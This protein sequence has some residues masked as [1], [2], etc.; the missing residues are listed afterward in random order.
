MNTPQSHTQ[1]SP[2]PQA[3]HSINPAMLAAYPNQ[4]QGHA[5]GQPQLSVQQMQQLYARQQHQQQQHQQHQ[6]QH[7]HQQHQQHQHQQQQ[8]QQQQ[9]SQGGSVNPAAL[10]NMRAPRQMAGAGVGMGMGGMV[11]PQQLLQQHQAGMNNMGEMHS[12]GMNQMQGMGGMS[13]MGGMNG[14]GGMG[15]MGGMG[16]GMGGIN[17][18]ALSAGM[19][20]PPSPRQ[21]ST[22]APGT[23]SA[24]TSPTIPQQSPT[25]SATNPLSPTHAQ[26]QMNQGQGQHPGQHGQ[27]QQHQHQS[28]QHVRSPSG[29]P[30]TPNPA[31]QMGGMPGQHAMQN[32]MQMNAQM[33]AQQH[34]LN[35]GGPGTMPL[36][37][38][39]FTPA[40]MQQLMQ[41]SLPE[42]ERIVAQAR[43]KQMAMSGMGHAQGM[44]GMGNM[45]GLQNMGGMG[46]GGQGMGGQGMG[47]QGMGGQ[48]M[49]NMNMGGMQGMNMGMGNM[50]VPNISNMQNMQSAQNMSGHGGMQNTGMNMQNMGQLTNAQMAALSM[51]RSASSASRHPSG[52]MAQG[53]GPNVGMQHGFQTPMQNAGQMPIPH[54]P[55]PN[56]PPG[57]ISQHGHSPAVL[58][59]PPSSIPPRPPTAASGRVSSQSHVHPHHPGHPG[60]QGQV[61]GYQPSPSPRPGTASRPGTSVSGQQLGPSPQ[62]SAT[63]LPSQGP[64]TPMHAPGPVPIQPRPPNLA[65]PP[66]ASPAPGT[67]PGTSM[68]FH[69]GG[70]SVQEMQQM[71]QTP[72]RPTTATGFH[73]P[74]NGPPQ[75]QGQGQGQG[76]QQNAPQRSPTSFA[77]IA[78]APMQSQTPGSPMRGAKRKLTTPAPGQQQLP[79]PTPQPQ[80]QIQQGSIQQNQG[81]NVGAGAMGARIGSRGSIPPQL[82]MQ[83]VDPT[84]MGMGLGPAQAGMNGAPTGMSRMV[85]GGLP[86]NL[87]PQQPL[88]LIPGVQSQGPLPET[89]TGRAMAAGMIMGGMQLPQNAMAVDIPRT[90]SQA[91]LPSLPPVIAPNAPSQ[92]VDRKV[93]VPPMSRGQSESAPAIPSANGVLPTATSVA[94]TASAGSASASAP[95]PASAPPPTIIPQLPPLPAGVNLNPKVT[96]VSVVPLVDS[97]TRIP[98]L[99]PHEIADIQTWMKADR[100]YE[101]LYRTMRDRMAEELRD[102]LGRPRAWYEQDTSGEAV[103]PRRRG[104]K[105]HL[106][107]YKYE[108]E[109]ERKKPGKRVGLRLP[110]RLPPEEADRPEQ[111]VPIRLEFDVEHHKMRDTFVWNLNDPVVTP[112]IFAQS[113]VEDYSLPSTYHAV[114]TKSIQDQL[115]DFKAHSTTFGEDGVAGTPDPEPVL[116]G[117]MEEEDAAW[118]EAWRKRVRSDTG[119]KTTSTPDTRSRKRRKVVKE[120]IVEQPDPL[121]SD[122]MD[123]DKTMAVHEFEDDESLAHE[124]MRILVKL[125]IIVG[126][127]KLED[128]FEWDMDNADPTP[129]QFAELYCREL[130][131]GG[132]FRTAI[133]HAIREQ[134]QIYQ[135]SLFLVGHPSD[136]TAVQDDDLRMSFLPSLTSAARSME[137]VGAFT[138]L[139]NYLSE[140]EIERNE[141][142]RE[143]ELNR[144][145]RKTARNRRGIALPDR[146]PLKTFRT[147]AIGFPEIDAATLAL[148]NAA[149]APTSRRA[150][151]AAASL[152]IASMVASENGTVIIPSAAPTPL[153]PSTP[154]ISK[155]KKPKGH[156]KAPSYPPSVLRPRAHVKAPTESTAADISTV[157]P[158]LE[159]DL[160]IPSGSAAPD[161]QGVKVV[162]PAKRAKELEREAKEKEFVDGQHANFINGVW[163]CS[164]CGCPDSV[165]VGRRKGP[166]GDKS[167]CGTCGKFWHRHRR[168]RPVV[169]NSDA[170]YHINLRREAE[171]AKVASKRK[172]PQ[173][174]PS[175]S[176][177]TVPDGDTD[178]GPSTPARARSELEV[179]PVA[180]SANTPAPPDEPE[181]AVSPVS[182]ASSASESPL[183][184]RVKMN[185]NSHSKSAP[186]SAA[187]ELQS[188]PRPQRQAAMS[189]SVPPSP[190]RASAPPNA[191]SQTASAPEWLKEAMNEM[192]AKYPEDKLELTLRK[193]LT[194]TADTL[195]WRIKCLDCPGKL[196]TP[197]P[198]ETLSGFEVH[199]KNRQHRHR[200]NSRVSGLSS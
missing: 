196:Y 186:A 65:R 134:V 84:T 22:P 20:V 86:Q 3:Q 124:E 50:Q 6:H 109:R 78:P 190:A 162:L 79:G 57:H 92:Q 140:N 153:T 91:R 179:P 180:S 123:V 131:L 167:Q 164:N 93:S 141:K 157:P 90:P 26:Q 97:M 133:A 88:Q 144:R 80:V 148:V 96:R 13:G 114:I 113:V 176:K 52:S 4:S 23:G 171:Q 10:M 149:A 55:N 56:A 129:E 150:A 191:P 147:P 125:D 35:A 8:Q 136:G 95:A 25:H 199:L 194:A 29:P 48:G 38:L 27:D 111:L 155:E 32:A 103:R 33:L 99:E 89:A 12:M 37:G 145:R 175:E 7:Q 127:V 53:Q 120:E 115:S 47:G 14:M 170:E 77:P 159:D 82:P 21:P 70:M 87:G 2:P 181:R 45:Q 39:P 117:T 40:Q 66:S 108:R 161:S 68:S 11:N 195:E 169:Y 24:A 152:T 118:W 116:K 17:P 107:G 72:S 67:R 110:R 44:G 76:Y 130:G 75:P 42:R 132:E 173:P 185:G 101:A 74:P 102:T 166:L 5:P 58:M 16:M 30:S 81:Q 184:E 142:E 151:A 139:L 200:V 168:P 34:H 135:K 178:A 158:P 46:M 61:Q 177:A 198:G 128:Q 119:W 60:A 51:Q 192:Q 154:N 100:E 63:P 69:G 193:P 183:A 187:P 94:S 73:Q 126:S 112:E 160:P 59:P 83:G 104:E 122:A 106:A 31:Q 9:G 18:A 172:R 54:S 156:F 1:A 71:Q 197:G 163:H 85:S 28:F 188:S 43:A 137:Q 15:N 19:G 121:G 146:D 49:Q 143:K 62:A 41:L 182:T 174:P 64:P 189:G 138:P 105:F 165:A 36:T 98:P